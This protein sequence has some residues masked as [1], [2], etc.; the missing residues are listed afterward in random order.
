MKGYNRWNYHPYTPLDWPEETFYICRLAPGEDSFC[1]EWT[2]P[3]KA[4]LRFGVCETTQHSAQ[5]VT[6]NK[7]LIGGLEPETEYWFYLEDS[8]GNKSRIRRVRTGA[9]PGTVV[10]YLH[11]KDS[12]YSFSGSYLCS[13][14]L[15]RLPSGALLASMD[16]F[17]HGAPQNL[18]LLF[19]SEDDGAT[20]QYVTDLF[21]CFWGKLFLHEGKLYM[22][23]NSREYGDFL[24]GCSF[25]EGRTWSEPAVLA[26]GSCC[27]KADGLHKAPNGVLKAHGRLWI[28]VDYGS[29]TTGRFSNGLFS[30]ALNDDFMDASNWS[31]TGFWQHD[32]ALSGALDIAGAIEGNP[33]AAPDGSVLNILR[34][35]ENKALVLRT[36]PNKPETLPVFERVME[37]PMGHTKF[38]IIPRNGIYYAFGNRLPMRATLSVYKSADLEHWSFVN[39]VL[40]YSHLDQ[41]ITAFQYPSVLIENSEALILSRTALNGADSFHDSNLITFH[42]TGL[43][44]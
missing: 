26:R 5:T 39:D 24:I 25:D 37:F 44:N 21:P 12:Y 7:F 20:W 9:V 22:A 16:L 34:Y 11:P 6:D 29:W 28:A 4:T 17:G 38:D 36:D 41:Q 18:T 30:V 23:A 14:S 32:S 13:P 10:N 2:G 27:Q 33:V 1:G 35:S 15:V 3:K 31:H 19:R 40:D 42:R 43:D 8:A